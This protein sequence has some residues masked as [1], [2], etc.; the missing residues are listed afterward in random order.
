MYDYVY[1]IHYPMK[2]LDTLDKKRKNKQFWHLIHSSSPFFQNFFS[3]RPYA[4]IGGTSVKKICYW[5]SNILFIFLPYSQWLSLLLLCKWWIITISLPKSEYPVL[6]FWLY[7]L[8][9][10]STGTIKLFVSSYSII[11][12]RH[13]SNK[14]LHHHL[15]E[16]ILFLN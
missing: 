13:Y 15:E 14:Y 10:C 7:C 6:V 5:R 11:T 8:N 16:Y 9:Y 1:L 2:Y 12:R 3:S 4:L